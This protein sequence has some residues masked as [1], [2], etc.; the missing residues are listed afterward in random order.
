MCITVDKNTIW[1]TIL[2]ETTSFFLRTNALLTWTLKNLAVIPIVTEA[3][4]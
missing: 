4:K 2:R 3:R 1:R